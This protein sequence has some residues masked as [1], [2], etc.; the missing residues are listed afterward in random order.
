MK[1]QPLDNA[2]EQ[3]IEHLM[4]V[5]RL[6]AHTVDAYRRDL[7]QFLQ[8]CQ[9]TST[10]E[11]NTD[12]LV[13]DIRDHNIRAHVGKLHA[14]GIAPKS[15]QRKLSS[16]RSF[17]N[18]YAQYQLSHADKIDNPA[19]DV[20]GPRA[21]SKLP[22]LL[23]VD[24]MDKL[25]DTPRVTRNSKSG[26]FIQLRDQAI[27]ETLY[28]AG[29]RLSELIALDLQDIDLQLQQIVVTGKGNKQRVLP[30]GK[31][32]ITAIKI[33]LEHRAGACN[34]DQQALF[35]NRR[36]GRLTQRS[37][38]LRLKQAATNLEHAQNL[39]PHM[40]RHSFASHI[41]E[42]SGD[43][44]AV[45]ELLG[46]ANLSTTQIY[47]HLDFQQLAEAYDQAHP[48]AQRTTLKKSTRQDSQTAGQKNAEHSK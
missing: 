8:H 26:T 19:S 39:H 34:S 10:G 15:I 12:T 23:D 44:R 13:S 42:S 38:Q 48:K 25:L 22:A 41:L 2:I 4:S 21:P 35:I 31:K 1:I 27:M 9:Q 6:S 16:I 30:L 32:A 28:G 20:R 33:W 14:R 3:F 24:Q 7:Q 18:Y 5:R 29:L 45:Q 36:G 46:H 17:F 43:L 37:V 47:T 40:L 11:S